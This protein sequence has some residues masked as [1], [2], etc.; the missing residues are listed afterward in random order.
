MSE[1]NI[2]C[3]TKQHLDISFEPFFLTSA[4]II[5][6]MHYSVNNAAISLY[7]CFVRYVVICASEGVYIFLTGTEVLCGSQTRFS[8]QMLCVCV[9]VRVSL[10]VFTCLTLCD[11]IILIVC[12]P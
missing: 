3:A 4:R 1:Q 6:S 10:L 5:F 12:M 7:L 8:A 11:T 2:W 9:F